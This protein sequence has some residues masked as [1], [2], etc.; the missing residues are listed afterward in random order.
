M[1]KSAFLHNLYP[2]IRKALIFLPLVLLVGLLTFQSVRWALANPLCCADDAMTADVAKSVA[3]GLGYAQPIAFD[4]TAGRFP[5]DPGISIGPTLILPAAAAIALFGSDARIPGLVKSLLSIF[6]LCWILLEAFRQFGRI[7][8]AGYGIL[9]VP[10]LFLATTGANFVQW[11]AMVGELTAA[12]LIVLSAMYATAPGWKMRFA[13]VSGLCLGLAI[14]TKLL[15][16]LALFPILLFILW[17]TEASVTPNIYWR[18]LGHFLLGIGAPLLLFVCWQFVSLGVHGSEAWVS[19]FVTFVH[20]HI[21]GANTGQAYFIVFVSRVASN[22][23]ASLSAYGHSTVDLSI[24]VFLLA[25]LIWTT[26]GARTTAGRL[27]L[28]LALIAVVN[29]TWWT[30]FTDGQGW[31]RYALIGI[32]VAAACMACVVFSRLPVLFKG[33][34]VVLPVLMIAPLTNP[35]QIIYSGLAAPTLEVKGRMPALINAMEPLE[36]KKNI[37]LVGSW[38]AAL[39]APRYLLSEDVP[40]VGFNKVD[41]VDASRRKFL[42]LNV[43]WDTFGH[44]Y[45]NPEFIRFRSHCKQIVAQNKYFTLLACNLNTSG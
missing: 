14:L 8:G 7:N 38:W 39:A 40:I 20:E 28:C 4:G 2:N 10:L 37:A 9:F 32:I 21:Q 23:Q 18:R 30:L 3:H 24:S 11:Y 29:L 44:Q 1:A 16:L 5:F 41:T 13:L 19:A 36:G 34:G 27:T 17:N 12:L 43:K 15:A 42:L 35:A 33:V 25:M 26:S 45:E 31:P 6:L 22:V